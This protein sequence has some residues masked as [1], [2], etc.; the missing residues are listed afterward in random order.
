MKSYAMAEG[1]YRGVDARYLWNSGG[2]ALATKDALD[3]NGAI[4]FMG[5]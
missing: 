5:R 1:E 3:S 4:T 2:L